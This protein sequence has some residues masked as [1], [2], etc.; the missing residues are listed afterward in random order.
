MIDLGSWLKLGPSSSVFFGVPLFGGFKGKLGPFEDIVLFD[1]PFKRK[2]RRDCS[3]S[4]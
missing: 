3:D 4:G 1:S 2:P